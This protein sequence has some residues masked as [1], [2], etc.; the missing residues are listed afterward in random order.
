MKA[1]SPNLS[2]RYQSAT[3]LL[4]DLEDFRKNPSIRFN[5]SIVPSMA[6]DLDSTKQIIPVKKVNEVER[7]R[8]R[9]SGNG[10]T[11]NR[12]TPEEYRK[13]RSKS[14]RTTM[15]VGTF[16]V[17]I[18][19]VLL[20][21]FMW[22]VAIK[23]W[24][25]PEN[26][27]R[28]EVLNFVGQMLDQLE[29]QNEAYINYRFDVKYDY[30]SDKPEGYILKQEP[31]AGRTVTLTDT[32]VL[33]TLTVSAGQED[34]LMPDIINKDY[35]LAQNE[36]NNLELNLNI[37][38]A[39]QHSDDV[40]AGYVIDQ[41][42]KA[43]EVLTPGMSVTIVYSTGPDVTYVKVPNLLN[44]T[45]SRAKSL[46]EAARL[47]GRMVEEY[48]DTT[49]KG[50]VSF[51]NYQPE[52]EV[53]IGTVVEFYISL[54]PAPTQPTPPPYNP[55]GG[56]VQPG[57]DN[58]GGDVQPGGEDP[59]TQPGG[60]TPTPGEPGGEE[61]PGGGSPENPGE[62][63]TEPGGQEPGGADTPEPGTDTPEGGGEDVP[64]GTGE[65]GGGD[66]GEE[67]NG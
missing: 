15:L 23:D 62:G 36:L 21:A 18:L 48:D 3:E 8:R 58:P 27:Q 13:N 49:Q 28:I 26:E 22:D 43:G 1:M 12:V 56:D 41:S 65:F 66:N 30:R 67:P 46:L 29:D 9:V 17:A 51:Q 20:V 59:G 63:Q 19:L 57:G 61:Q 35:R 64:A 10:A 47:E 44:A 39:E 25:M 24:L 7:A 16:C 40:T 54:G 33:V 42:P 52:T 32:G 34:T 53:P 5:Y 45:E 14:G 37:T 4:E 50:R 2:A 6:D 60:D 55:G 11:R 31:T 38:L